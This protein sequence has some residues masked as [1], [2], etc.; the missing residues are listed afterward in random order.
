VCVCVCVYVC[1]YTYMRIGDAD[2]AVSIRRLEWRRGNELATDADRRW[3]ELCALSN[4]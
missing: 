3:I 1:I 2:S 4:E